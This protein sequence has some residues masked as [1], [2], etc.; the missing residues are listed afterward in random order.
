MLRTVGRA[1]RRP[2]VF[3]GAPALPMPQ[4]GAMSQ[5]AAPTGTA[6]AFPRVRQLRLQLQL[7]TTACGVRV[8]RL[9]AKRAAELPPTAAPPFIIRRP[10]IT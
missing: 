8:T 10:A 9:S 6:P 4:A 5:L 2:V 7:S 1:L 3:L